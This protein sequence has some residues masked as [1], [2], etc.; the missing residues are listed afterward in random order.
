MMG[1]QI[2]SFYRVYSCYCNYRL[3]RAPLLFGVIDCQ[4]YYAQLA[5]G[6]CCGRDICYE[7][8]GC[9]YVAYCHN[10]LVCA[11]CA[12]GCREVPLAL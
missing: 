3:Y 7:C 4:R 2:Y 11:Y 12:G 1:L 5:W 6:A 10:L 8:L 9:V